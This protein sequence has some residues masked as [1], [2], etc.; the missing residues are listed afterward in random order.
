MIEKREF[1]FI[2]FEGWVIR[3]KSFKNEEG[4][5]A[6]LQNSVPSD[7]YSS[8]AYY[9]NPEA[10][11]G[12]KG[13]LGADLIFDIDADHVPTLC[14]KVH[15]EWV[16]CSCGLSG[17]GIVPSK[18]PIC[19]S[20]RFNVNTWLC[21]VCLNSAKE[22]TVKLLNML[23]QDFGFSNSELH[24]FFS[25]HR[26]YH[27][28]VESEAV[29]TLDATA[30]KEIVDYI[31]GLGLDPSLHGLSKETR[32]TRVLGGLKLSG[33]GWRGRISEGIRNFI[34]NAGQRDY[35]NIGLKRGVIEAL[36]RNKGKILSGHDGS[37][38]LDAVKGIG[39]KTW[40]RII[41]H[42][43][44]LQSAKVDV[45][46]TTDIHRLIRLANTLHGKTGLKKVELPISGI[47]DFDPFKDAVAFRKGTVTV[48]TS[49]VPEFRLINETFGPYR[50]QRVEL[51]TAVALLLVCKGRA[52][53]V[54]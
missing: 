13:W 21:E 6:F 36:M 8:C 2:L 35:K 43:I 15:D 52:E 3:H 41:E 4:L 25:G 16:C 19:N 49:T 34:S 50:N 45:I 18:C 44:K 37:A 7:V 40:K 39:P 31:S 53:V 46:V 10:E 11:M 38:I 28:H 14:D 5:K 17:K 9:E 27:V 12:N 48:Q 29:R 47:E 30:R 23:T 20:G 22:E 24:V 33:L 51:P 1:G 26:G 42:C 54:E 32:G